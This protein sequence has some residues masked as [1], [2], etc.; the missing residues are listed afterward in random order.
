MFSQLAKEDLEDLR[1]EGCSPTDEDVVRLHALGARVASGE[2]EQPY[3]MPRFAV[4]GGVVFHEPT[5][6]AREWYFF[7]KSLAR[8]EEED[9]WFFFFACAKGRER[10]YLSGLFD[11][12]EVRK[13]VK[14]F[15]KSITATKAEV[16]LAIRYVVSGVETAKAE[17]TELAKKR[18]EDLSPSERERRNYADLERLMSDAAVAT[19][20]S[21][22]DLMCS[23][24]SRLCG[25]IYSAC[26]QAGAKMSKTSARAHADY[27][28]TLDA[29]AKRLRA[30]RDAEANCDTKGGSE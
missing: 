27:L 17:M 12:R 30:E 24:P 29:I 3:N 18:G 6:A 23:T 21:F 16:A 25:Y 19:G 26:V 14:E 5:V 13:A 20:L 4:C 9:D 22:E 11:E 28:A 8:S 2:E 7:A 1:A 10:G 15:K